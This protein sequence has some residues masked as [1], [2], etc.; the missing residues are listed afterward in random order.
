[1]LIRFSVENYKSFKSRQVFSMAA[2]KHTRLKD[3]LVAANGKRI[4]K[5]GALFGPNASGKSNLIKAIDFAR[6]IALE[7]IRPGSISNDYFRIDSEL[8]EK[9]G[10]FQFDFYQNGHFYSYGFAVSYLKSEFISEWLYLV[11]GEREITIFER[12]KDSIIDT[13]IRFL[14]EDNRKRFMIYAE[15]AA[16]NKS[17]LTEIIDHKLRSVKEFEP[18]FDTA[19][20]LRSL[21]IIFPT[22][23]YG[24]IRPLMVSDTLNSMGQLLHYFDTGIESISG[25][26]KSMEDALSFLS[27]PER[28]EVMTFVRE[29]LSSESED[30]D[31]MHTLEVTIYGRKINFVKN[32]DGDIIGSQ[33]LMNHGN[34]DD[35]FALA[36]E[37]DGT[38][39]LFDLLPLYK[40]AKQNYIIIV[41][42]LDRSFHSKLTIEFISKF[43]ERTRGSYT[44]LIV[45][46]HD[47]YVMNLNLLRQ[48]EIWFVERKEDHSSELYSLNKFKERFDHSVAK[49]YFLGR[50]GAVPNFGIDPWIDK[51]E[52][53]D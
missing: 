32:K 6:K 40:K 39:R 10:V 27:E 43:F 49:D 38:K 46:L 30:K 15:D 11:E 9:P 20:W 44:Q 19:D 3:H 34:E 37:S 52:E 42:E 41:D 48:D 51:T 13:D 14:S 47:L 5:S 4:L 8:R 31:H 21:I 35:L 26:D 7:G 16:D 18:F 33:F 36:D 1:M 50:Y 25:D 23:R 53:G 28:D 12:N 24:N 17:Y 45:T 29:A 22:S 2:A